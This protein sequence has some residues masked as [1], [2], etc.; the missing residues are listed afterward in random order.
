MHEYE[1]IVVMN[2]DIPEEDV[3]AAI[4]RVTG[5]VTS[6]GGEIADVNPWGRRKLAYAIKRHSEGHYV[7]TNIRLDPARAHELESAFLISEDILRHMLVRKDE[8]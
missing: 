3:Q 7:L 4:D 2:P 8:D 6:R 1:L 5:A